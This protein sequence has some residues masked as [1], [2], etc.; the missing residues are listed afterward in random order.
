LSSGRSSSQSPSTSGR[1]G[2]GRDGSGDRD[3]FA[4]DELAIVLSHYDLG[5][6]EAIQEFPRG[7]RRAPKLIL[8]TDK[9]LYLLKRRAHGKDD[10]FKVAFCHSL[11]LYLAAKQFPLPHLI[12]TFNS[13]RASNSSTRAF[14]R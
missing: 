9:G 14:S 11:Q 10:P 8:R 4:A 5:T 7:S 13:A 12:G 2:I 3:C 1:S 6:I